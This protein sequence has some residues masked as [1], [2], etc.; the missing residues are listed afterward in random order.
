[1]LL[2]DAEWSMW[3]HV[4]G[5]TVSEGVPVYGLPVCTLTRGSGDF[6][7]EVLFKGTVLSLKFLEAKTF[8]ILDLEF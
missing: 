5:F 4:V 7:N 3:F 1:M 8:W 6:A 2:F